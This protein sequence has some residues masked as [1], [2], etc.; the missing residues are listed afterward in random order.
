MASSLM[1]GTVTLADGSAAPFVV[2]P[3][4]RIKAERTLNLKASDMQDGNIGEEYLAYLMF[5]AV[6]RSGAISAALTFD[7]FIDQLE[8]YEVDADPQSETPPAS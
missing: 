6:K 2:G 1:K 4:E 8:D 5:E 7:E 3:R